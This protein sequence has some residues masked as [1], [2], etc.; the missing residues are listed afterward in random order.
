MAWFDKRFISLRT[1][2]I[3]LFFLFITIP[4]LIS[5]IVTYN[6]Y[7][8]DVEANA[9]SYTAQ[10][11]DQ[12][13]VNIDRYVKEMERLT[14]TPLYDEDVLNILRDHS[15]HHQRPRYLT[16]DETNKMNLFISS[17]QFDRSEIHSILI[18]AND[19]SLFSS[20]DRSIS[21]YWSV[22]SSQWMEAVKLNDGKLTIVPPHQVDYYKQAM[23]NVVSLARVI[24]EPYTHLPIGIVKVDLTPKGFESIL[25]SVTLSQNSELYILD[26]EG[27][28]L[29]SKS[30]SDETMLAIDLDDERNYLHAEAESDYTG[31]KVMGVV[32]LHDLRDDAKELTK[33]TLIISLIT[34]ALAYVMAVVSSDRLVKPIQHLRSKMKLV[35]MGALQERAEVTTNDE[36]GQLTSV[37]N[38]MIEHIDYLVKEVYE[39]TLRQ[40]EAELSALQEQINPHFLYNTLETMNMLALQKDNYEL[41]GMITSLGKLLHYT[42]DKKE[43]PVYLKDEIL[44]VE[45]YLKIQSFRLGDRLHTD[46]RVDP[47]FEHCLVPKLILQPLIENVIE[48]GLASQSRVHLTLKVKV[49]GEDLIIAIQDDGVGMTSEQ[50]DALEELIY[51]TRHAEM[52]EK[53]DGNE[54]G[55]VKK[56]YALRNVHQRIRLLYGED[57]GLYID[58]MIIQGALFWIKIPI[59]WEE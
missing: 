15:G 16:T 11:M 34:L 13:M 56:G 37:F 51:R 25:S 9:R 32:P 31:I 47:S 22:D 20:F 5:G 41:S 6:K 28:L 26:Q 52:P 55:K 44:F 42:V 12:I 45:S 46:I 30:E 14:I 4:F 8:A 35:Q 48:H 43:K 40:R 10:I 36:I 2:F 27:N 39:S 58:K 18:F 21:N 54:F 53:S 38:N 29:Y 49:Q 33:F 24:R 59:T 7:S 3:T 50:I 17:L 23:D 1:K 19:G 57:Y